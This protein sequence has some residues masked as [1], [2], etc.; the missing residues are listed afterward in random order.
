[1]DWVEKYRQILANYFRAK[2]S[3]ICCVFFIAHQL[4]L[5]LTDPGPHT[6]CLP[7]PVK[8][9]EGQVGPSI[10]C[11]GIFLISYPSTSTTQPSPCTLPAPI[12]HCSSI[13]R[14]TV[15]KP[16]AEIRT[17]DWRSKGRDPFLYHCQ[18][19]GGIHRTLNS[20]TEFTF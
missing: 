10:P 15:R 6:Y 18:K 9:E 13:V 3:I 1:M 2:L 4:L 14:R 12:I 7:C 5:S 16:R 8:G 11:S 17:R 20:L 19:G